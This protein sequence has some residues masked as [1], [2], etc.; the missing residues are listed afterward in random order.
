MRLL[1]IALA[2]VKTFVLLH[3]QG[4]CVK[5]NCSTDYGEYRFDNGD[6][7]KGQFKAGYFAGQGILYF[8]SGDKYL[9]N[10]MNSKRQG[11][12]RLEFANGDIYLGNFVQDKMEGDG[13]MT[14]ADGARYTGQWRNNQRHGEG[15]LLLRNGESITGNWINDQYQA[16]WNS[17]AIMGDTINLRN[18]NEDYCSSGIGKFTYDNGNRFVG[19]FRDGKPQ[20]TG[21]LYYK[22]GDRYEGDWRNDAPNGKGVMHY[23]TGNAVGAVWEEGKLIKRLFE[24]NSKEKGSVAIADYNKEVKI[25]AVVIGAA[26]YSAMPVLRYTDDDAYQIF[27]FLKS[28]EGGALPDNQVRLLIDED[29]TRSN[30]LYA[31]RSIFSKAD[32]ND[33]VLFYFSG[34][35]IEG[36]FLPIDYDG[37]KNKL[38]HSEVRDI[39]TS[40]RAKHKIVLADACHAGGLIAQ[41]AGV[42]AELIKLYKAFEESR[43]G[44]A[45][46]MSSKGEE[47]SLE[48]SGLRSGVFSHFVI[49]GLKGEADSNTNKIVSVQELYNFVY[50]QVRRYTANIQTPVLTGTFD[51]TMPIAVVR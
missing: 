22:G 30:V 1:L 14:Y 44:M 27:A 9:G 20:G 51:P 47:F 17:V 50:K 16:A 43:G 48:D 34:H 7:Y 35:G 29:A 39:L 42:D 33:V 4:K 28:P 23:A 2:V 3:A 5:G 31:M 36:A 49:R 37:T 19:D 25:W 38:F 15:K 6:E 10:W 21:I 40:S 26:R 45:L 13:E 8:K 32:E 11:R 12:G 46:L 41:K 18:C 24:E